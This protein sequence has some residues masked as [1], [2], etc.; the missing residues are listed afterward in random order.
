M[1]TLQTLPR[2]PQVVSTQ[3]LPLRRGGTSQ[4]RWAMAWQCLWVEIDWR[5][6][7]RG[8]QLR[9]VSVFLT[10]GGLASSINLAMQALILYGIAL[11]LG[12]HVHNLVAVIVSTEIAIVANFVLNDRFTFRPLAGHTRPWPARCLRFHLT[13]ALG[14]VLAVVLQVALYE[15]LHMQPLAANA[16]A[17]L[18]ALNYSFLAHT[19]FTY[20]QAAA[21]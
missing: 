13:A 12:A 2:P 19:F 10:I 6:G 3:G 17:I 21:H 4:G 18:I 5:S 9:K 16:V 11:P 7:G 8:A 14:R 15:G 1:S 20:R